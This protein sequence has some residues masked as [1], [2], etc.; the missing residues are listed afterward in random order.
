MMSGIQH[1]CFC[2][3]QWGLIHI[4]Q[5]WEE[6]VHTI[7][8]Q[9]EHSRCHDKNAAQ[10]VEFRSELEQL[11]DKRVDSLRFY[12]LGNNYAGRVKHYGVHNEF[13]QDDI[14]IL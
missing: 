6:N 5:Q 14:L 1:F 11:I 12:E 3:R 13:A 8:G 7:K 9:L 2:K 10:Y 4:E